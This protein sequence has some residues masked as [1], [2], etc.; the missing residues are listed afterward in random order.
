MRRTLPSAVPGIDL[1]AV[2]FTLPMLAALGIS[3][4]LAILWLPEYGHGYSPAFRTL[5]FCA[6]LAW[7]VPLILLQRRLW[8]RQTGWGATCLI[9]LCVT[10]AM[11]LANNVLGQ[12]LAMHLGLIKAPEWHRIH[13]GLDGCWLALI[14]FCAVHAVGAYYVALNRSQLQLTT[15]LLAAR[16]AE[17]RALRYQ[18]HPH[19]LFNTL[20][21]VSALV[22][23]QRD[24][25]ATRM[26]SRLAEF[27]RATLDQDGRHE[28][29]LADEL[30]LTDSYL[31]IEKARLGERLVV[32][33][34]IGPGVL[35]AMVPYLILQPLIE[36]AIRHGIAR[37]QTAGRLALQLACEGEQLAIRIENDG[38]A[39]GK[40]REAGGIGLANI[41]E[42]LAMLYPERHEFTQQHNA[43]GSYAVRITLPLRHAQATGAAAA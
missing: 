9:L 6:N 39:E 13:R 43:D 19:F 11:S 30:A 12:E 35:N 8:R 23:S 2:P 42:R 41:A 38:A 16:D 15:A 17:L 37:R 3:S 22:V 34:H 10:Y 36:N 1:A 31:D 29:T 27:L 40:A 21:T 5:Y 20:N 33:T 25:E 4:C 26:I 18:L 7:M 28:H 32:E 14:A 24:R